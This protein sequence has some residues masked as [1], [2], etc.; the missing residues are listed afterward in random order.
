MFHPYDDE[1]HGW[2]SFG[3]L[4]CTDAVRSQCLPASFQKNGEQDLALRSKLWSLMFA[5]AIFHVLHRRFAR[6]SQ[7]FEGL[8]L[9]DGEA[10]GF[11]QTWG[12][13]STI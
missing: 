2:S 1:N 4:L 5:D 9:F 12:M 7:N 11:A 6:L 8:L 10:A 13:V 3:S